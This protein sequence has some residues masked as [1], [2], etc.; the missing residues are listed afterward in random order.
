[1]ITI[2]LSTWQEMTS[3]PWSARLFVASASRTG[4]DQSPVKI[5]CVVI[6]GSTDCA[7]RVKALTLRSTCGIGLAPT[8]PNF[9]VLV[10]CPATMPE[11]YIASSI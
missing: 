11:M 1:M 4:S 7:P 9:F 6:D 2:G 10:I 5:T 8:K 3:A